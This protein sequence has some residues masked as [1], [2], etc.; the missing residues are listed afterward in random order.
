MIDPVSGT[1]PAED[2]PMPPERF[3]DPVARVLRAAGWHEGRDI[4]AQAE[5]MLERSIAAARAEGV[6]LE[7]FPAVRAALH[8]FG[9]LTVTEEA[10]GPFNGKDF[11]IDSSVLV[12]GFRIYEHYGHIVR[13][14]CFPLGVE[15]Q[16]HSALLM[17]EN[18]EVYLEHGPTGTYYVGASMDAALDAMIDMKALFPNLW[19]Y[20]DLGV[21]EESGW[22]FNERTTPVLLGAGWTVGRDLGAEADEMIARTVAG[23]AELGYELEAFPAAVAAI[24]E[25]GGLTFTKEALAETTGFDGTDLRVDPSAA[26]QWVRPTGQALE[27]TLGRRCFPL[28]RDLEFGFVLWIDS[29]GGVYEVY[30][31]GGLIHLVGATV[32]KAVTHWLE[33]DPFEEISVPTDKPE[34]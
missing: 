11:L 21:V 10:V 19:E 17:A 31:D 15:F 18:G 25:F 3:T 28:G 13:G 34:D 5:E 14:R 1:R 32:D 29:D 8:E 30:E 20:Y 22:R 24:H 7:P 27:R 12:S 23:A 26:L 2:P 16:E 6:E 9:G 33:D 4:G